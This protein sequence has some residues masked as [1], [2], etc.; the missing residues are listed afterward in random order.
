MQSTIPALLAAM[1][2]SS[3][4]L[5][6]VPD[7]RPDSSLGALSD[8]VQ[9]LVRRVHPC[10]VK[11]VAMGFSGE[12]D[13][14]VNTGIVNRGQSTGSGVI[15]DPDGLIVTNAHVLAGA[16][17]VQ[18][19]LPPDAA[20]AAQD[21]PGGGVTVIVGA[22][23]LGVDAEADV[24]L[25]KVP[26]A[27]LPYLPLDGSGP[28]QQ[29]QV[30]LA[31]GSP[32]GLDDSVTLGVISSPAR[33][34][35]P[36]DPAAYIQ[37]D[38]PINPGS[39]GGP[40]VDANGRIVGINTLILSQSG[41]SE[42]LGFAVPVELV[43]AVVDQLRQTGRVTQGDIGLQ[44]RANG[45]V[46]AH[47]WRLHA[48]TG[49][50]VQDVDP[51][52]PAH[53]SGLRSG[54]LVDSLD[55]K[56]LAGLPQLRLALYRAAVGSSLRL[57]VLRDGEHSVVDVKVRGRKSVAAR[58]AAAISGDNLIPQLG[59]FALD[60]DDELAAEF[61][62]ARGKGGVLVAAE[63][64]QAPVLGEALQVDDIIYRMNRQPIANAGR[65]RELLKGV[66]PG[67]PVAFQVERKGQLH[68]VAMELP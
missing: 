31:F 38:A 4:V 3:P 8:S 29:G 11:I 43:A 68:F 58:L 64:D 53:R 16:D 35:D 65:L 48:E 54:D 59:V 67:E 40:L 5:A 61:G 32:M 6:Q 41:G 45:P 12:G 34:F 28:V 37:T 18:V 13:V 36:A 27:G 57:G 26:L 51:D 50:V 62:Q 60:V 21:Q 56:P 9:A 52:G 33:Q 22:R 1:A 19:T 63:L 7:P 66:R 14:G 20:S 47:A 55:G 44:A 25:L 10:V 24:A 42:G 17:R 15:V 23:V 46:I 39:S 49:V 30:V 2:L